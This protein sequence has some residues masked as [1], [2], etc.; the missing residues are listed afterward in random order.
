ML[1][2][3]LRYF[4]VILIVIAVCL[5][6]IGGIEAADWLVRVAPAA[7]FLNLSDAANTKAISHFLIYLFVAI[8]MFVAGFLAIRAGK[9][10]P[11][12]KNDVA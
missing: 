2:G 10:S 5:V 1:K 3:C 6:C 12:E 9:R 11:V 7:G 4:G 8:P